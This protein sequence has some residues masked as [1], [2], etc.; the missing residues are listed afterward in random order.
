MIKPITQAE[1]TSFL[2]KPVECA[3]NSSTKCLYVALSVLLGIATLGIVHAAFAIK[4]KIASSNAPRVDQIRRQSLPNTEPQAEPPAQIVL[5]E[6]RKREI[7]WAKSIEDDIESGSMEDFRKHVDEG[8]RLGLLDSPIFSGR[9]LFIKLALNDS[10]MERMKY[11]LTKKINPALVEQDRT[12]NNSG[13]IWSIANASHSM[14]LLIIE[15]LKK[16]DYLNVQDS[17]KKTALHLTAAKGYEKISKQGDVLEHTSFEIAE[18]L[19]K[20]GAAVNL[21]DEHG[22]TPLHYACY[23]RDE[24]LIRALMVKGADP[25]IRNGRGKTPSEIL[26]DDFHQSDY[27]LFS[28][29][30]GLF[31]LDRER[32]EATDVEALRQLLTPKV[33]KPLSAWAQSIFDDFKSG[34]MVDFR[35]HV[36]EGEK[37]GFLDTLS[38]KGKTL[39]IKLA[40]VD[41]NLERMRYLLTKKINPELVEDDEGNNNSGLIW[42][43][44]NASNTMALFIIE[45]LKEGDYLNV[46]DHYGKTALHLAIAKGYEKLS[47]DGEVLE[48][49]N[50]EIV[51][52]LLKYRAKVNLQDQWGNTPLHY[53]CYRRDEKMIKALMDKEADP[54]LK[55]KKGETPAQALEVSFL[56]ALNAIREATGRSYVLDSTRYQDTVDTKFDPV[57]FETLRQLLVR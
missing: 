2:L 9:S 36:D 40:L 27:S 10:H 18:A 8:E 32:F 45:T 7:A 49:S 54:T 15:T 50:F 24:K 43:I 17:N 55:N 52:A 42:S 6:E 25:I 38:F 3:K 51:E 26:S 29:T 41:E 12:H 39:F 20:Y 35:T 31:T 22:N 48:H 28:I 19:L 44:A 37:L 4:K 34:S 14:A 53:A 11:L 21:Q 33:E 57:H 5:T 23:R 30:V 16:G 47:I 56:E 1:F 13:L 46:R